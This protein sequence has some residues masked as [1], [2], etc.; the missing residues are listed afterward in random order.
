MLFRLKIIIAFTIMLASFIIHR[1]EAGG[2]STFKVNSNNYAVDGQIKYMDVSPYIRN[3]RVYMP[4]RY[5]ALA[6]GLTDDNIVWNQLDKSI[7]LVNEN[8]T[9]KFVIGSKVMV[10]NGISIAMDAAPEILNNRTMLPVRFAAQSMGLQ[11]FWDESTQSVT[12]IRSQAPREGIQA[13]AKTVPS[14]TYQPSVQTISREFTWQYQGAKYNFHIEVPIE[15]LEWDRKVRGIV[16]KY[17]DI[18]NG[19]EQSVFLSS[20]PGDLRQLVISTSDNLNYNIVPWVTEEGNYKFAGLLGDRLARQ[21]KDDG[22]D[23]FRTAEFV[24]SFVGGAIP[25]KEAKLQLPAQTLIDDGDC[26]CK[27][28]LLSAILKNM[29]YK[30]A[31]LKYPTHEAVGIA[32]SENQLP[33]GKNL[34]YYD[35]NGTKYFFCETT[36]AGWSIGQISD[37]TMLNKAV[38]FPVN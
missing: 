22:Y 23:Y 27:S 17:Y 7:T 5:V 37:K 11:I 34:S 19:Y 33:K 6:V 15:L 10:I 16:D 13:N 30:V 36:T 25:Y 26:D 24:L 12:I 28:V 21:A 38:V 9:I 18:K 35:Y 4:L 29:G 2:I 3:G 14:L 20:L 31:L 32:F 1:A 8:K